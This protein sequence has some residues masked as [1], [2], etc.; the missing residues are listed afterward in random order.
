MDLPGAWLLLA[1]A[2]LAGLLALAIPVAILVAFVLGLTFWV[3]YTIATIQV[4]P[5]QDATPDTAPAPESDAAATPS[6][7]QSG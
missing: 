6:E 7:T 3:G 2:G 4:E 5:Y 1:P